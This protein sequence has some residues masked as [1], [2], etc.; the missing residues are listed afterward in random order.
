MSTFRDRLDHAARRNQ[1]LLCVGLDLEPDMVAE[2]DFLTF[3]REVV[4][5]TADQVCAYSAH[6]AFYESLGSEGAHLL[7]AF[8]GLIPTHIPVIALAGRGDEALPAS[9]SARGVFDVFG[10]DAVT[11]SPYGGADAIGPFVAYRDKG[12]L[13]QC[14]TNSPGADAVQLLPVQSTEGTEPLY[15]AIAGLARSW[16]GYGNVGLSVAPVY[17]EELRQVRRRCPGQVVLVPEI[18]PFTGGYEAAVRA[19]AE[20]PD[21]RLIV[22]VARPVLYASRSEDYAEAARSAAQRLRLRLQRAL[23]GPEQTPAPADSYP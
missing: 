12:V 3:L 16:N 7:E 4:A 18:S 8:R 15:L 1:S 6:L 23:P 5:A 17:A 19:A 21:A 10:F 14:R 11:V 22:N 2:R 20:A 9:F 13:V